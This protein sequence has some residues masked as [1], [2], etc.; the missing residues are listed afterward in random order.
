M[1][2]FYIVGSKTFLTRNRVG[3]DETMHMHVLR[4]YMKRISVTTF[5]RHKLGLGIYSMQGYKRRNKESKNAIRRFNNHSGNLVA[6][7]LR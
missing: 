2:A 1:K 3:D 6:S 5:D 7:N 4:F